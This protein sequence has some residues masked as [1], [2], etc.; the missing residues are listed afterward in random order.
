MPFILDAV[1]HVLMCT[2]SVCLLK[3]GGGACAVYHCQTQIWIPSAAGFGPQ[4]GTELYCR[5]HR[6]SSGPSTPLQVRASDIPT[7]ATL[8]QT[9]IWVT[10]SAFYDT[11]ISC[12]LPPVPSPTRQRP[13][14]P[15]LDLT[16]HNWRID[17]RYTW[18]H[19]IFLYEKTCFML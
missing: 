17:R 3:H 5:L 2:K 15:Y 1:N 19:S 12:A 11:C 16:H 8:A 7:D 18:L 6:V 13:L 14:V 9:Q 10:D 4:T